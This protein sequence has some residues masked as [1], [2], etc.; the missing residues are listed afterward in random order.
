MDKTAALRAQDISD[1]N[2]V[3]TVP[4]R[5]SSE[6]MP[7]GGGDIG[8]NVWVEEGEVLFYLSRSGTF[9]ENNA[10]LK[11]GR[12]RVRISSD[13]FRRADFRQELLLQEGG[14]RINGGE[15]ELRVWVDVFRP[16]VHVEVDSAEPVELEV[17][18][19]SWRHEDHVV[20]GPELRT[21]SYK[22][23]SPYEVVTRRDSI[24]F[25]GHE[26][27][28]FHRNSAE[29]ENIF[30]LTVRLQGLEAV[31]DQ[32]FDPVTNRTFG[33]L[34]RGENLV[35]AGTGQGKYAD[36]A[37][38]FW[39]L[40]SEA[41]AK[42]H[43]FQIALHVAQTETLEEWL[44]GLEGVSR[45]A[46]ANRETALD[47]TREWWAEF[48]ERSYIYIESRG[49]V[50]W[51]VGRNYQLVRYMLGCNA[52]GEFPTKFNGGLFTFD[53]V[54]VKQ[55]YNYSPDFRLWAGGTM[56][57]QNQRLVYFPLLKSGDF[58]LFRPQFDFYLRSL[59]N[60][61]LR[62]EVYWGHPGACFTEQIEQFG[63]PNIMEYGWKRPEGYD[64]GMEYNAWLEYQWD[65][66][67]E[68]CLMMLEMERY[69][70]R[71]I[72]PYLPLIESCLTFY[73]EHYRYL[74]RRRGVKQFN[75]QGQYVL[76]P[77]T[78]CE[79]YKMAY[80]P[81]S[82]IAALRVI[83]ERLLALPE[84]YLSAEQR[85]KWGEMLGRIPPIPLREIE[86][87]TLIAPAVVWERV[88]N[89]ETP[90]L[91]PVFPW[92]I[93]GIGKP[94]L[95][96]AVNT[97][98]HDPHTVEHRSHVGWRQSSIFAARLSLTAEAARLTALKLADSEVHRFPAFWGPAF[99]WTPDLNWG[100]SAMIG[101]QEMLMQVVEEKIYLLPAWPEKWNARFRLHAPY[102]TVV[103]G[104]VREGKLVELRVTPETRAGDVVVMA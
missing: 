14:I 100:G 96:V 76:F 42:S 40:R 75:E 94:D 90:Q 17:S 32:M 52:Y 25:R 28:F 67:F 93:Y 20:T 31:K 15:V 6:S 48:W 66:V 78:A 83:L 12:V 23:P 62:S 65:T 57:A 61:E 85:A 64:P 60:A 55:E 98:E 79:T 47:R 29:R 92:G 19:E 13:P 51:Q 16:V 81:S 99:D 36:T 37:F 77:G 35:V 24:D 44:D 68:F 54:F 97:Y 43:Q 8:L 63:L 21:T 59:R 70:G 41:A 84:R 102:N 22:S 38:Q 69:E 91:Y 9:D 49:P 46:E 89:T 30:D 56:T 3:W 50:A 58:D 71:D 74:A 39:K 18:Y 34:L 53:P 82:T 27:L 26:V 5:D 4:S 33:G 45:E 2:V 11:L 73:D 101:L 10:M 86:G 104:E 103:E 87:R 95:E 88:Q 80:N 7:C 72:E 1:Y